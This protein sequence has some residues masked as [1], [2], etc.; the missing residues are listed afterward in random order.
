MKLRKWKEQSLSDKIFDIVNIGFVWFAFLICLYPLYYIVICSVSEN[1]VGAYFWPNGFTLGGYQ[2]IF[3]DSSVWVGYANTIFYTVLGTLCS[4]I[5]T[6]PCAYA[7]SRRDLKGRNY[8]MAFVMVTMFVSGGLVPEYLNIY[9]MGLIDTRAVI[10]LIS[11]TSAHNIIVSRSFFASTIPQE[12][13]EAAKMDGCGNGTFFMKVVMPLS[14]PITAVMAV[15]FGVARWNSYYTEMIYLRE[16]SKQPLS[17]VLRRLLWDVKA[18]QAL[19]ESG[20]V[21]NMLDAAEMISISTVIQYAI[22]VISTLPMMIIY[23][24]LQKYFAKGVMIGS[25]KG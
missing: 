24:H 3:R 10:I 1:V 15:Y 25:V 11:L 2:K 16:R 14:K 8:V 23:P 17:L 13:L 22:I 7:L 9:N 20:E 18:L 4:L 19:I 21:Q 5:V 12:L 6:L